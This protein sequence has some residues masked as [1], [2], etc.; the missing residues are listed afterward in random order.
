MTSRLIDVQE[1]PQTPILVSF[2]SLKLS[3]GSLYY[4]YYYY[5]FF[6][7]LRRFISARLTAPGTFKVTR[8]QSK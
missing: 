7:T 6:Y 1:K 4:Y 3:F 5:H 8:S 2:K